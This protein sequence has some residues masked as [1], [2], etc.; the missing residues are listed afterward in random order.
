MENTGGILKGNVLLITGAA[1]G[2]GRAA[3]MVFAREGAKL[4]LANIDRPG[5][6]ISY[7]INLH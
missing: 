1:S 7:I 3:A 2:I 5:L 4:T 6:I